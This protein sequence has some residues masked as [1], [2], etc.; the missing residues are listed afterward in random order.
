MY[1]LIALSV[2][3]VAQTVMI[4]LLFTRTVQASNDKEPNSL[5]FSD[6]IENEDIAFSWNGQFYVD[7]QYHLENP[8]KPLPVVK[9]YTGGDACNCTMYLWNK[10]KDPRIKGHGTAKNIPVW[11]QPP[12]PTGYV[13][14]YESAPGTITGHL[15]MYKL[16]EN[17]QV[18][19]IDEANY[20]SCAVTSGRIVNPS[21]IKGFIP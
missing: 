20:E 17:N 16:N 21:V 1:W 14:T 2:V 11:S 5:I 15:A 10:Y 3:I 18:E 6:V 7:N 12:Y 4:V 19:I 9:K 8:K 13:V